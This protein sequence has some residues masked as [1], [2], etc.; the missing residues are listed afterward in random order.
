M[1]PSVLEKSASARIRAAKLYAIT[2]AK[3]CEDY[4]EAVEK[5]IAG[6]A[7]VIQLRGKELSALDLLE[8]ARSLREI[9][10]SKGVLFIVNDRIDVALASDS[11]GVHLG[12]DDLPV[13]EARIIAQSY[14]AREGRKLSKDFLIG[15]STHS[16][17]QA[18]KAQSE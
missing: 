11:D 5:A 14:L 4:P 17:E 18:L 2:T 8:A 12:Q 3:R 6:G 16:I 15:V 9:C 7:D 10:S 1:N 13:G